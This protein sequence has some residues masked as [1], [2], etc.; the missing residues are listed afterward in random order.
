[1]GVEGGVST[2]GEEEEDIGGGQHRL[3]SAIGVQSELQRSFSRTAGTLFPILESWIG[4]EVPNW[5][6]MSSSEGYFSSGSYSNVGIEKSY[7]F[8]AHKLRFH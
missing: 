2:F 1:M 8:S 3:K 5:I 6:L 4:G 7:V